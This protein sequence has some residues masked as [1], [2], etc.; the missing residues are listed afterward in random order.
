M[1]AFRVHMKPLENR[2]WHLSIC[3]HDPHLFISHLYN[4]PSKDLKIQSF[5]GAFSP[6]FV[7]SHN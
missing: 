6:V 1:E 7:G 2:R 5:S 3:K 4:S